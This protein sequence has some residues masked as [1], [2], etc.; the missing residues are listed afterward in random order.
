MLIWVVVLNWN[1]WQDTIECLR[2]LDKLAY[3]HYR[4]LVIDNGS[5]DDS[6]AR[7]KEQFP[8]I[9]LIETGKNLGFAG[10]NNLGILHALNRGA[11]F[12]W[13]LNNDTLV[14]PH[15][16]SQLVEV[17]LNNP[18]AGAVG[19]VLYYLDNPSQVQAWGGGRVNFLLGRTHHAHQPA[20]LDYLTAASLLIRRRV[21]E[22]VGLLDDGFFMYWE[23]ADFGYRMR[24]AG[25][26]LAVAAETRILHKESASSGTKSYRTNLYLSA[27]TVRF[28]SKHGKAA[29]ATIAVSIAG[30]ALLRL[31]T[32]AWHR[33]WA[34]VKG[35]FMHKPGQLKL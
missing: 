22:S 2:S 20:R 1:G 23:D 24:K 34:V 30:R 33:A 8:E 17:A 32:G 27:S 19:S 10:A 29:F 35:A 4:V 16:L 25:W 3:Q 6:V 11:E 7:I 26:K 28:F 21:F 15:S 13:L 31:A 12:V 9:E 18:E 5:T 14:E